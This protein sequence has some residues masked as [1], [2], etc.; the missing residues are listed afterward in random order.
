M[1]Q[2][3]KI[4]QGEKFGL[5]ARQPADQPQCVGGV[6]LKRRLRHGQCLGGKLRMLRTP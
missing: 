4:M 3:G 1:R 6:S 2:G 5:V